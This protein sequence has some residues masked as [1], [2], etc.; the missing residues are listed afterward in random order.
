LEKGKIQ[1][2][3]KE[4]KDWGESRN[5]TRKGGRKINTKCVRKKGKETEWF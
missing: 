1:I 4:E 3:S 2:G 5:N